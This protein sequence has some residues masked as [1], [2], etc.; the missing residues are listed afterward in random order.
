MSQES[1]GSYVMTRRKASSLK[2]SDLAN[3][4]GYTSQAISKFESGE[5]QIALEVLPKLAN[6][7]S[8]SLD[9]LLTH[10]PNPEPLRAKN[11][12]F[13]LSQVKAN[14]IALRANALLSQEQE[15]EALGVSKRSI[16]SYEQGI[17]YPS[18]Y[19]LEALLAF[20]HIAPSSF[21]YQSIPLTNEGRTFYERR[22]K[23]TRGLWI[24]G[25]AFLVLSLGI[26]L[27]F[28]F[29]PHNAGPSIPTSSAVSEDPWSGPWGFST[30]E[31]SSGTGNDTSS[32]SSSSSSSSINS[33]SSSSDSTSSK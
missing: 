29:Q 12:D 23:K 26:G 33:E 31:S 7:L 20:Y 25:I 30:P 10:N 28:A 2:Q 5:S 1:L 32:A 3:A 14:L 18:F 6:L 11:P 22:S 21:F 8:L 19:C 13:S 17:S 24:G 9:D 4:L 27:P 15:A 16:V